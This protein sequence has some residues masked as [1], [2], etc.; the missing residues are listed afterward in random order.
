MPSNISNLD[1]VISQKVLS[2]LKEL[3]ETKHLYQSVQFSEKD[4][5]GAINHLIEI[6]KQ[7]AA[8]A[9]PG[10]ELDGTPYLE[11]R[12][13]KLNQERDNLLY[14]DWYFYT[15]SNPPPGA[16]PIGSVDLPPLLLPSVR[17]SCGSK[18]CKGSIQPHNAG[19]VGWSYGVMSFDYQKAGVMQ[20][21]SLPYQCQ[22]CREE[23]LVFLVTRE[24]LKLT[25][26]GRSQFPEVLVPNFIPEAQ[27]KFY[28]NA[29]VAE[30]TNFTLAAA[31]YLRTVIEQYFYA[32]IPEAEIKAIKGN[33]T[34]DELAELYAKTL[35]KNFPNNF[36]SLKKAYDDLSLII[37][38]GKENDNVKKTFAAIRNAVDG[39]FK[40]V[41]LFKDMPTQ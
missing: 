7:E 5:D 4:F 34:G 17:V 25:L 11:N 32:I 1:E 28:R 20:I 31:L 12:I 22:N 41:Q 13:K 18:Q 26:V 36:P 38:S 19:F 39:H 37:H 33:P 3:L 21:F 9:E 16:Q 30:Q 6:H 29:I 40:A 2:A 14:C 23:P 8:R 15:E 35:P 24:N 10:I 27:R